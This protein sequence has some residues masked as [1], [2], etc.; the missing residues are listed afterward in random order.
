[1]ERFHSHFRWEYDNI[2]KV[3]V[4]SETELLLAARRR[5][6][7]SWGHGVARGPRSIVGIVAAIATRME[8]ARHAVAV[9]VATET[10]VETAQTRGETGDGTELLC[11]DTASASSDCLVQSRSWE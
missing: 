1:M 9:P 8:L 2:Y 3:G 5:R 10:A 6:R 4:K 7:E 11:T